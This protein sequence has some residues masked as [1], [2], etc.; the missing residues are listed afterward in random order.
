NAGSG[1]DEPDGGTQDIRSGAH[2][3][4]NTS[5]SATGTNKRVGDEKRFTSQ[6]SCLLSRHTL[7]TASAE[8]QRGDL[9]EKRHVVDVYQGDA[10]HGVT[11]VTDENR[12]N[13]SPVAKHT[14]GV[15]RP[16]VG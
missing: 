5:V 6:L 12:L 14:D 7:R 15:L 2:R 1:T 9:F 3:A 4:R 10:V 16:L 13:D 8:N 11:R